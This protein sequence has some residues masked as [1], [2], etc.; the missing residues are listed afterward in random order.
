MAAPLPIVGQYVWVSRVPWDDL[1]ERLSS[2]TVG[3]AR[4]DSLLNG[5]EALSKFAAFHWQCWRL[6]VS[7]QFSSGTK[8][9]QTNNN[10]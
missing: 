6:H 10:K 8:K 7:E 4:E 9:P 3:V 1:Y 2:V 5:A